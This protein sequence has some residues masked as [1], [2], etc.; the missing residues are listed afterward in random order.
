ML[1]PAAGTGRAGVAADLGQRLLACEQA[2]RAWIRA[3]NRQVKQQGHGVR[4]LVCSLPVKSPWLNPIEPKWVH[5]KRAI[6][7]P[8]GCS[9]LRRWPSVC[10][11]IMAAPMSLTSRFLILS[12]QGQLIMH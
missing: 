7:E 1:R 8:T 12:R 2:V 4:I 10:A 3:H 11:L 6:V 5:S 9:V